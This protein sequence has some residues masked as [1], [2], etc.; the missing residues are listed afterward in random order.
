MLSNDIQNYEV[1]G[2]F[3]AI[4]HKPN[5]DIFKNQIDLNESG[6]IITASDSTKTS[7]DGVFAS[8]DIQDY[9]YMQAVTAAGS[10][11]MAAI[12]AERFLEGH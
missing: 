10:G 11:C 12:E 4:G 2:V 6:Y 8:G 9:I 7:I 5:S 3:M 1:D